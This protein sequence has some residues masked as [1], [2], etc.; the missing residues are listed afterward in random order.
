ML[1]FLGL[2]DQPVDAFG[3]KKLGHYRAAVRRGLQPR[4]RPSLTPVGRRPW[5]RPENRRSAFPE[6]YDNECG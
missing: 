5:V 3:L 1:R 6:W 4:S 2:S